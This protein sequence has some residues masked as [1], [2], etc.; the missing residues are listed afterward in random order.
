MAQIAR[1][2]G[3]DDVAAITGW[4][5]TRPV[6]TAAKPAASLPGPLPLRCGGVHDAAAGAAPR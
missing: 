1:Q 2:L 6:P 3:G 4:L 5:A